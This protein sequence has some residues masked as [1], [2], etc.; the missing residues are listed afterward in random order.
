MCI[1]MEVSRSGSMTGGISRNQRRRK[2]AGY[3]RCTCR[4]HSGIRM[5]RTG[6]AGCTR[7]WR[8]GACAA[9]PE[10]V[11]SLMREL[12]LEPCQPRP[13]RVSLTEERPRGAASRS[14][15]PHVVTARAP[16]EKM[17]GDITY[18]STWEGWLYLA[19]VI[20]C[21]PL[22][23][24]G[25]RVVGEV[26]VLLER[27]LRVH[28]QQFA[29]GPPSRARPA[30][31]SRT[32]LWCRCRAPAWTRAALAAACF[33]SP[34]AAAVAV[35]STPKIFR[36]TM[37]TKVFGIHQTV[38][39]AIA[40]MKRRPARNVSPGRRSR[41]LRGYR[42]GRGHTPGD[43]GRNGPARILINRVERAVAQAR[44]RTR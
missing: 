4:S 39:Q 30:R 20:D 7:T 25:D 5:T 26:G 27:G 8:P 29:D 33:Q 11:R 44:S 40:A 6:T 22:Q 19:T 14:W 41:G 15:S 13:W 9:G 31:A 18:I 12:G 2:G 32:T 34:A 38:D 37:L 43:C 3:S 1:W 24:R 10:L 23:G 35:P 21:R 36:I 16:G 17:V 42:R 28:G